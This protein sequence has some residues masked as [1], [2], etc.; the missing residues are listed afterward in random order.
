MRLLRVSSSVSGALLFASFSAWTPPLVAQPIAVPPPSAPARPGAE[1]P[2]ASSPPPGDPVAPTTPSPPERSPAETERLDAA[3]KA[4]VSG[5]DAAPAEPPK[6]ATPA[7]T[8]E[9]APP[10]DLQSLSDDVQGL[11]TDLENFKFQWQH[12]IDIHTAT[13]T[14][15]LL[16]N[17]VIQTRFSYSDQKTTNALVYN[18]HTTFDVP[19]AQIIFNG[20]LYK[21]YKDG[22]N[23]SY[24]LRFGISQQTSGTNII[25]VGTSFLNLLD[26]NISYS[27][28]PTVNLETP[29]LTVTVGQ[30]L[31]PF[32]IEVTAPDE[33]KP[34]ILNAQFTTKLALAYRDIGAIVRGDLFTSVDYGYNYRQAA[35]AYAFGIV[36]G[37]G[38]S[39]VDNNDFKNFVGRLAFTLPADYNSWLRQL[40]IGGSVVLGKQNLYTADAAHTLQGKGVQNRYGF[41]VYYNHWPFGLTYE[42]VVGKDAATPGTSPY[43]PLRTVYTSRSH[44]ATF[45]LSFGEQFEAGYRNQ[46]KYDDWWPKTFQPFLRYDAFD[47]DIHTSDNRVNVYTAGI[48]VFFAETTK[49]QLNYNHTTNYAYPAETPPQTNPRVQVNEREQNA[50]LAQFQFG[51]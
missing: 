19:L 48:N 36:N 26:A 25:G 14:R 9:G 13:T 15:N 27:V 50:V 8:G 7:A 33:L 47:P 31:L 18:R 49:F 43:E 1:G 16:M 22:R 40:T 35:L 21:D 11:R 24:S 28:L 42:F 30:Q 3:A 32:G 20:N 29:A 4:S 51:F 12:E 44:T 38:G 45:F 6:E 2:V 23:L 10:P 46:G 17:G 5:T 41:D 37:S 39:V 34:V